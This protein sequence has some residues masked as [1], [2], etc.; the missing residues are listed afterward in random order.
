[1]RPYYVQVKTALDSS[2]RVR[3]DRRSASPAGRPVERLNGT[4]CARPL[5]RPGDGWAR[6]S[7]MTERLLA[8]QVECY[9]GYRGEETPVRFRLGDRLVEVREVVDRWLAPEHRYF[10][11]RGEDGDIYILRNDVTSGGWEL[12]WFAR[13]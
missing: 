7:G 2:R 4:A 5:D 9:A 13:S 12:T 6:M 11:V 8:V 10:K 3:P 1:M